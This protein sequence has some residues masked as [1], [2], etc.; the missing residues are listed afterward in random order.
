MDSDELNSFNENIHPAVD[1]LLEIIYNL[2]DNEKV[3]IF[4]QTIPERR[5]Y[6]KTSQEYNKALEELKKNNYRP[7]K[8]SPTKNNKR[9]NK[10]NTKR[11]STTKTLRKKH[12]K[13]PNKT[14]INT[15][16]TNTKYYNPNTHKKIKKQ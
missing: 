13:C 15:N 8:K 16:P 10:I 5:V 12:T 6:I 2:S 11:S 7:K 1:A 4:T 3:E 14:R 9:T